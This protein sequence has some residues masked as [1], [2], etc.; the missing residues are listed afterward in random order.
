[1][2]TFCLSVWRLLPSSIPP[3]KDLHNEPPTSSS[4]RALIA[5]TRSPVHMK[6]IERRKI[7]KNSRKRTTSRVAEDGRLRRGRS[8]RLEFGCSFKR[9][10]WVPVNQVVMSLSNQKIHNAELREAKLKA[11]D[12]IECKLQTSWTALNYS[13][14]TFWT[15]SKLI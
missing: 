14:Q 2:E 15:A 5:E 1:M 7:I 10:L 9:L 4:T 8:V 12:S 3:L 6:T 13:K 11:L